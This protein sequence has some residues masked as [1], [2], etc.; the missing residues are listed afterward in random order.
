MPETGADPPRTLRPRRR[1]NS[2]D[3]EVA[4]AFGRVIKRERLHRRIAQDGFALQAAVDRSYFGKL[5]R[6]ERQPS[7]AVLL[8][9]AG[10]LGISGSL[11]L[12]EVEAELA[13]D[14]RTGTPDERKATFDGTDDSGQP[15]RPRRERNSH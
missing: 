2:F 5:E 6:G 11:L 9:V 12:A 10:A 4:S 7:L 8:R 15:P 14:T 3:P 1:A 13:R